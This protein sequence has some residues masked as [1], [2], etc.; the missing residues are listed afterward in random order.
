[1]KKAIMEEPV[2][3]HHITVRIEGKTLKFGKD[4]ECLCVRR[5]DRIIWKLRNKAPFSVVVKSLVSPVTGCSKAARPGQ[6]ITAE[7]KMD[8]MP[9]MQC[10]HEIPELRT[11]H[12]PERACIRRHHV[13]FEAA[14]A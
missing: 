1:M 2:I 10:L 6:A 13:H 5:G 3:E 8:A 14:G 9:L 7:V 12:A 4:K 11:K